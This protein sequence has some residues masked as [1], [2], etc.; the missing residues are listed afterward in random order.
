MRTKWG[1]MIN[2]YIILFTKHKHLFILCINILRESLANLMKNYFMRSSCLEF[3][4]ESETQRK[5]TL[6]S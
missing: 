1:K 6:Y 4:R 2:V 5:I 3:L